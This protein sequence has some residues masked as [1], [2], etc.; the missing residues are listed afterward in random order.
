MTNPF[1]LSGQIIA[2]TGAGGG[3]GSETARLCAQ[4]GADVMISD[5]EAP[6][7]LAEFLRGTGRASVATG[8]DVS[9]RAAVEAW[10]ASCGKADALID[11][12]AICPFD[13]WNDDGWDDVAARVFGV[14]LQGPVN[15]CRAFMPGMIDRESGRIALVGSIAGRLGGGR[16]APHYVMSKG[17][18]H[19]YVRWLAKKGAPHNVLVNAVAPA[20]VATAMTQGEPFDSAGFPMR[21]IAQAAEIAGPLAFLV[22]PA[23]SYISG[24]VLDINGAMHFS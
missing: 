3:I 4:M 2:I 22:S 23:A 14:N 19:A 5:L 21:R 16:A 11:C 12:A 20:P 9:D 15:L 10:A 8:L 6:E 18:I 7:P 17:G 24:A 1:D 13:D